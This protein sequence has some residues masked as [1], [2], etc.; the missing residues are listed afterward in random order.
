MYCDDNNRNDKIELIIIIKY[1]PIIAFMKLL[2]II[3]FVGIYKNKY[4]P[5]LKD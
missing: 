2:V 4:I 1:I 5:N 3:I